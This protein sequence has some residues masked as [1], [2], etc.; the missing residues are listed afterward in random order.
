MSPALAR[1]TGVVVPTGTGEAAV[2]AVVVTV[3]VGVA[4]RVV[5]AEDIRQPGGVN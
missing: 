2:T 5:T 3:V 4:G 1:T